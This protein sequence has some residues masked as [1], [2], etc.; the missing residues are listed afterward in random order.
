MPFLNSPT[1]R[2]TEEITRLSN[3]NTRIIHETLFRRVNKIF[4]E[5]TNEDF[6]STTVSQGERMCSFC[7]N[8][9]FAERELEERVMGGHSL[10]SLFPFWPIDENFQEN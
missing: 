10:L 2:L 8:R 7:A 9:I 6:Q 4:D 3:F 1:L 5:A